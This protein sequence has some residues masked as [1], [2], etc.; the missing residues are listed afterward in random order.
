[1]NRTA[2]AISAA[3][4]VFYSVSGFTE[5]NASEKRNE[6][7]AI[8]VEEL[9]SQYSKAE[10]LALLDTPE[11]KIGN[12]HGV[13]GAG[14]EIERLRRDDGVNEGKVKYTLAQGNF[15]HD[16]LPGWNY[17]FY[18]GRE[19]LFNGNLMHA[20]YDR[21]V[22][23]IQEVYV[24]RSYGMSKG[25]IGWGLKLASESID[26]RTTPEAKV[27]GS[28]QLTD[29][30]DFHGYALYHVE[31]KRNTGNFP[32]WEVEPGFGYR[33]SETSGAWLNLRYQVG[34]WRPKEGYNETETEWIIKPGVWFTQ[35]KLSYSFWGEF[36]LFEK[37]RDKDSSHLWTED[38]AKLG[39]SGNYEFIKNWRVF[40]EA[41][42]KK[43]KFESGADKYKFDGYIPLFILG[44]NYQF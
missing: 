8:K 32:Y 11:P 15:Y 4:S 25:S 18:S 24:N 9:K 16:D 19:D 10:L 13:L 33:F 26:K 1:M 37:E 43:I 41:S 21:G 36:G 29:N 28:Y 31:Y 44:V 40:G 7:L 20:K 6:E 12:F 5:S 22:N 3:L 34:Q 23:A 27:F 42:Y 14:V 35:G 17:G 38:Y 39:V 2:I 30:L